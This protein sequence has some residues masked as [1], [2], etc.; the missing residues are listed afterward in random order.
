MKKNKSKK[1]VYVAFSADILHEAHINILKYASKLG[2]VTVGLLTDK[3]IT[4]YRK[5]PH[6]N[7]RQRE[8]I[9]KN[10]RYVKKV[11][12]QKTLDY[13]Q[14][15]QKIKPNY[16]VHGDDWKKGIQKST[17][18]KVIKTLKKWSGK[19]IEVPYTKNIS[20]SKIKNKILQTG[21]TPEI[22]KSKLN[23]LIQ[24]KD[25]VRVLETHNSIG[26]LIIENLSIEKNNRFYEFDGMWSSSLTD[27]VSR[28]KP[29]NQSVDISTRLSGLNEILDV[30]TKPII[31]DADNGGRIEHISYTVKSL[32]RAGVAAIVIEDKIGLK[33][34]S[35]FKNQKNVSQDKIKDFCKKIKVAKKAKISDNFMIIARI[36]S[37]ILGK[38][39]EDA[40]KRADEYSKAGADAILIHSKEKN[41]KE[42]FAFAKRFRKSKFFKPMVAVPS[43]YSKTKESE[44]IRNGF[45]IVIYANHMLRAA[46]PAMTEAAKMILKHKRS[47]PI[48]NK[49]TPIKDILTLVK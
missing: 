18:A 36:E 34:N 8:V 1:S 39:I 31:F 27:S 44:L 21:T 2:N 32:E 37:L 47:S 6:L 42:I 5:L 3:A 9:L 20:S 7:Y 41:P 22:R 49:I 45:K 38:K 16:V 24:V 12:Q 35:L 4:S 11:V 14:N 40:L 48:E 43:T 19:L 17:R 30:T 15:L 23:R 13:T 46:Y 10:I 33:K 25:I 28:G 29:D 26:G